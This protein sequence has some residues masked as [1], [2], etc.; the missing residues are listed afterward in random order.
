MKGS[1]KTLLLLFIFFFLATF[2][3]AQTPFKHVIIVVQE[4]RTPDNLFGSDAQSGSPQLPGADLATQANCNGTLSSLTN[5]Q[6]NS[7]PDIDHGHGWDDQAP[8]KDYEHDAWITTYDAGKM[9]GACNVT[10]LCGKSPHVC[11]FSKECLGTPLNPQDTYVDN[12]NYNV[13]P[14]FDIAKNYGYAN[15]M[16]QTNQ[17][18]SF[19][20]HQFLFTGT[21]AP[22][23]INDPNSNCGTFPC[24]KWFAAENQ[25]TPTGQWGCLAAANTNILEVDSTGTE[26]F[27]IYNGGYPCYEHNTMADLLDHNSVSWRYYPQGPNSWLSLWTA[28]NAINH[29][30]R[31]VPTDGPGEVCSG[32][33]W[34]NYVQPEIPPYPTPVQDA[35]APILEDIEN[36]NLPAVSW[37]IPDG[38]SL[39]PIFTT[40]A[41]FSTSPS[42]PSARTSSR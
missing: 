20:A 8:N 1:G 25:K 2:A 26:H 22:D 31:P 27:G 28:P 37:V 4:N 36:C 34:V 35:M 18:P 14:Y 29:I 23:Y 33:D 5:Y 3:V 39:R 24:Y 30:C 17:G 21:S 9:D 40:S 7:C 6:L 19:E 32:Q 16:F 10:L 13:K 41:V 12:S 42:G 11:D 15:Y 38:N